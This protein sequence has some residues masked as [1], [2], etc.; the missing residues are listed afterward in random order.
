MAH[1]AGPVLLGAFIVWWTL[2]LAYLFRE[3]LS[4]ATAKVGARDHQDDPEV[5]DDDSSWT[6]Q[7]DNSTA[8]QSNGNMPMWNFPAV[9][10]ERLPGQLH[11]LVTGGAGY[12]GSHMCL[13]LLQHGHII[14]VVDNLSRGNIGAIRVL[15]ELAE[16]GKFRFVMLDI[17]DRMRL[18]ALLQMSN[19]DI[20][21]H[22]AAVAYVAESYANPLLYHRNITT[23]TIELLEAMQHVGINR[24]VYSSTCATYGNVDVMPISE[25]TPANPVS[26]Y[27]TAK[28]ASETVIR[29][30]AKS[31]ANF[32]GVILRYFNVIGSD[33]QGQLGEYPKTSSSTNNHGRISTACFNAALGLTDNFLIMG[34]DH[35]TPDGTCVRDYIHVLDL[36]EA[37]LLAMQAQ[38]NEKIKIY[39]VGLGK[40]YSVRQFSEACENVTGVS[41]NVTVVKRRAGDAATVYADPA[42]IK[43][44]LGWVPRYIDLKEALKTSWDWTRQHPSGYQNEIEVDFS[45]I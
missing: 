21:I 33:P 43:R 12:I 36:V 5:L 18:R 14:T 20:V 15:E 1:G 25:K 34:A 35:A 45:T 6:S 3:Q 22:F 37:H 4:I 28:L 8:F 10:H 42:L 32:T 11:I 2:A 27:G 19:I 40:G 31:Q 39:N 44:E 13:R 7:S 16:P 41:L 30:F 23:N 26:P 24:L 17:G 29:E 9:T 38:R